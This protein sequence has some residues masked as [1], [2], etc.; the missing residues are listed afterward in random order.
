MPTGRTALFSTSNVIPITVQ[1]GDASLFTL[2]DRHILNNLMRTDGLPDGLTMQLHADP[3]A[4]EFAMF[5]RRGDVASS[6][7][8]ARDGRVLA[9]W[10]TRRGLDI[11]RYQTMSMVI[12]EIGKLVERP[13]ERVPD[14]CVH[15]Q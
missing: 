2:A 1:G 4:G 15:R 3:D 13:V 10:D 12:S 7:A 6:W 9:L 5:F 8:V 11:G 14:G